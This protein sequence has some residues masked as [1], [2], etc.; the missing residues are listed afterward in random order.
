MLEWILS[1]WFMMF[2]VSFGEKVPVFYLGSKIFCPLLA[3][4]PILLSLVIEL[5]CLY[6]QGNQTNL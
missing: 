1:S 5:A 4:L 6:K 2:A 3:D